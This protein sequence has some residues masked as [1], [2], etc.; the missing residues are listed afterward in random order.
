M[1]RTDERAAERAAYLAAFT[2]AN[3]KEPDFTLA[4]QS[5]W[6]CL[7]YGDERP[8]RFRS[9]DLREMTRQLLAIAA[10]QRR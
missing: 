3:G 7:Q 4:W 8:M 9:R 6:W 2:E 10:E 5:G 1:N